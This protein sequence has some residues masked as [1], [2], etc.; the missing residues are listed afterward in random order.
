MENYIVKVVIESINGTV[1]NQAEFNTQNI[2]EI[3]AFGGNSPID[4]FV[5]E[6]LNSI[7]DDRRENPHHHQ[8]RLD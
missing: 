7:R 5:K 6:T 8:N 2:T 1:M 3:K 4:E